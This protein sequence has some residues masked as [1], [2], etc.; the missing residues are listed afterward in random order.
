MSFGSG[1]PVR[2]CLPAL[3]CLESAVRTLLALGANGSANTNAS[4]RVVAKADKWFWANSTYGVNQK[5]LG[6]I[7]N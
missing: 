4:G 2:A 7:A 1:Q 6:S 5:D 3:A